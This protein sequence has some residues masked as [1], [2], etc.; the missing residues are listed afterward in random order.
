LQVDWP[1]KPAADKSG[2]ILSRNV[3]PRQDQALPGTQVATVPG[4]QVVAVPADGDLFGLEADEFASAVLDGATPRVGRDF[5]L[6]NMRVLDEMRR[7]I[8]LRFD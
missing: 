1:W 8:G 3:P 5:T 2:Y 6:G 4:R 7:Q